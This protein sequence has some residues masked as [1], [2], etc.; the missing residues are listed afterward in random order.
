MNDEPARPAAQTRI[1]GQRKLRLGHANW[2]IPIAGLLEPLEFLDNLV[3]GHN[4]VAAVDFLDDGANLLQERH[5]VGIEDLEVRLAGLD[6]LEDDLRKLNCALATLGKMRGRGDR[7]AKFA[8]TLADGL[9]LRLGVRAEDVDRDDDRQTK[10]LEVFDVLGHVVQAA[11]HRRDIRLGEVRRLDVAVELERLDGGHQHHRIGFQPG[12]AALDVEELL[13]AEVGG[14]STLRDGELGQAHRELG[15][16]D[17]VAA[18]GDVRKRATVNERG[19]V[20]QRLHEI[21][22]D[23]VAH[24]NRHRPVGLE[25]ARRHRLAVVG[26]GDDDAAEA[27]LQVGQR[28]GEAEGRHDFRRRRDVEARLAR[29]TVGA[30]AEANDGIAERAVIHVNNTSPDDAPL[31]NVER[32]AE[33]QVVVEHRGQQVVR[34][35]DDVEVAVE[36][37]VDFL[38]RRELREAAAGAA[39]F[40]AEAGTDRRLAQTDHCFLAEPVERVGE[41]DARR[42]LAFTCGR[43]RD[44]G[45]KDELAG[46]FVFEPVVNVGHD[47]RLDL[48]VE[49]EVIL[50]E[51]EFRGNL[52][53]RQQ[54]DLA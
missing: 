7:H 12:L 9:H 45:D 36:M 8:T 24:Q 6:G 40:D 10:H 5:V 43:W 15:G 22:L 18:V 39:A 30:A 50:R 49:F 4:V 54:W 23:A 48:A 52:R 38:H 32:V 26:V 44:R 51:A 13:R 1:G 47:L 46:R 11:L 25:I 20:L 41:A 42:G 33:M 37:E 34:G 28:F 21:R 3:L 2:V 16:R 29:E 17:A 14:K 53:D 19:V 31:V 27:F 35:G